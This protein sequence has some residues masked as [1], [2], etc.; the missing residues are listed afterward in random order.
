MKYKVGDAE[1]VGYVA[2]DDAATGKRPGVL[3]APE[4]M[5]LNDYARSRARSSPR[6]ATSPSRWVP[7]D[8]QRKNAADATEAAQMAGALK[9]NTNAWCARAAAALEML[10]KS[11]RVDP[12]KIAAI[13]YCYG[14]TTVAW[15]WPAKAPTSLESSASTA[16]S[17]PRRRPAPAR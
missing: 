7:A 16:T 10:R 6:W 2:Y 1:F 11:E 8:E 14:G 4:W 15:S 3:V 9:K 17:P 13:G 12:A 5:G